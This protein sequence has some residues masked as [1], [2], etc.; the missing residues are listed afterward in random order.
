MPGSGPVRLV[1]IP[2]GNEIPEMAWYWRT[3]GCG[4]VSDPRGEQAGRALAQLEPACDLCDRQITKMSPVR[5]SRAVP[6]GE[7]SLARTRRSRL[8]NPGGMW[9]VIS[10]FRKARVVS[11]PMRAV[12]IV[13]SVNLLARR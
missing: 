6:A 10:Y 8:S 11:T 4:L 7:K 9:G 2:F 5:R 12:V 1:L 3:L 13:A